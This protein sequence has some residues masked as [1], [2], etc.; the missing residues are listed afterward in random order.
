MCCKALNGDVFF[1]HAKARR[2][3]FNADGMIADA[4]QVLQKISVSE[5]DFQ[6]PA[7]W[8]N[9]FLDVPDLFGKK[10]SEKCVFHR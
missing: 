4:P 7:I 10:K 1:G 2:I 5:T 9:V 3:G 8:R 6:N